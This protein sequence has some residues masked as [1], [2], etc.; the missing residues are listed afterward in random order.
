MNGEGAVVRRLDIVVV[1]HGRAASR[2]GTDGF[3]LDDRK[4]RRDRVDDRDR[5]G[6]PGVGPRGADGADHHGLLAQVVAGEG[7]GLLGEGVADIRTRVGNSP[8]QVPGGQGSLSVGIEHHRGGL[9]AD[10]E[11]GR[12]R[13]L[14]FEDH[15][16][17]GYRGEV[18]VVRHP[19]VV[20]PQPQRPFNAAVLVRAVD[21][22][23]AVAE[24]LDVPAREVLRR[25]GRLW[26][27]QDRFRRNQRCPPGRGCYKV[28]ILTP[29]P[30]VA[31][32]VGVVRI[33]L[34]DPIVG[35]LRGDGFRG[36]VRDLVTE[37]AAVVQGNLIL[38]TAA[39]F[40]LVQATVKGGDDVQGTDARIG[41][42]DPVHG[43][44]IGDP[45][46]RRAILQPATNGVAGGSA[47]VK[48]IVDEQ[49]VILEQC[50]ASAPL[51]LASAIIILD[52]VVF[53][54]SVS[55]CLVLPKGECVPLYGH[56]LEVVRLQDDQPLPGI[57][58]ILK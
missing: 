31:N 25:T 15:L 47:R 4:F 5:G 37:K 34:E 22:H 40:P 52:D 27:D 12:G 43:K 54:G 56:F 7:E 51:A 28:V 20:S 8:Y 6:F 32:E 29:H 11:Y 26:S 55:L 44:K 41:L 21:A 36:S 46:S 17:P 53:R 19:D 45:G 24:G 57:D 2:V 35:R 14:G 16:L 18:E 50:L 9:S 23:V 1:E 49:R 13:I 39:H 38:S 10:A 58:D 33:Q 42:V 30:V 3:V 48:M